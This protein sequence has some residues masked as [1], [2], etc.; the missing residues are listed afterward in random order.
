MIFTLAFWKGA[1]ERAVKTA[2]QTFVGVVGVVTV[3]HLNIPW[4]A[5]LEFVGLVTLLSVVT[6]IGNADFTAGVTKTPPTA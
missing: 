4:T 5:D 3:G 1:G 2:A 6:S